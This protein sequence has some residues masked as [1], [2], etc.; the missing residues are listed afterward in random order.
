MQKIHMKQDINIQ[1][2]IGERIG[3]KHQGDPKAFI[4][5]TNE[6]K[7]FIKIL[8]NTIQEKNIKY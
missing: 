6:C 4:E 7:M 2:S 5:Q 1:L 3:L 8:K